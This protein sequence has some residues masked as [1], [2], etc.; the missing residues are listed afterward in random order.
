MISFNKS[1]YKIP[2]IILLFYTFILLGCKKNIKTPLADTTITE[3][4]EILIFTTSDNPNNPLYIAKLKS[5]ENYMDY[6][7][8]TNKKQDTIIIE[9]E[10]WDIISI[11]SKNSFLENFL[12][13]KGDTL[14]LKLESNK[15]QKTTKNNSLKKWSYDLI[16]KDNALKKE[17]DSL[18]NYII[19]IDYDNSFK[20]NL[21]NYQDVAYRAIPNK[22]IKEQILLPKLIEKYFELLKIYRDQN[23]TNIK[24]KNKEKLLN[25]LLKKEIFNNLLLLN[26]SFNSPDINKLLTSDVFL[27]DSISNKYDEYYYLSKLISSGLISHAENTSRIKRVNYYN[28]YDSISHFITNNWVE[29]ARMICLEHIALNDNNF[30]ILKVKFDNFN[31]N[32]QNLVFKNYMENK[33]LINL[34]SIYNSHH[35][36]NFVDLRENV[37][38]LD[39]LLESLKGKHIYIDYWASWCAPCIKAM[40]A[41]KTLKDHYKNMDI[42]F[43]YFSID[44]NKD[45]WVLASKSEKINIEAHNYL[46]LNHHSSNQKNTLKIDRIPRYLIFNKKGKLI[47]HDAPGPDTKEIRVLLDMY[48]KE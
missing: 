45:D 41:S 26:I 37:N 43:V 17:V 21:E 31:D 19:K 32:Y 46:I 30:N 1:Y 14:I 15:I 25:D 38:N 33:H 44:N 4:K 24:D 22:N 23:A 7:Y 48:L 29:K 16:L 18:F 28:L 10:P 2:V 5:F 3:K 20:L 9:V 36:V 35:E 8:I 39:N 13:E 42:E 12:I 40:P 34:K 27:S 11:G 47:N 6:E